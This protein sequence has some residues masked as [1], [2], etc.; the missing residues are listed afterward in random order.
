VQDTTS[1]R[2]QMTANTITAINERGH[3]PEVTTTQRSITD[4]TSGYQTNLPPH[5]MTVFRWSE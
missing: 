1:T 2:W 5:S 3:D 4:F